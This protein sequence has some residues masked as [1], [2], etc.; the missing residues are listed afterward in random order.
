LPDGSRV[1]AVIAPLAIDGP[2]LTIRKFTQRVLTLEDLVRLGTLTG[3]VG[4]FLAACVT[5]RMNI[6]I[7]GGTGTSNAPLLNV[8]SS[9]IPSNERTVTHRDPAH[10]RVPR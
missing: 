10:L 7:S 4:D 3:T 6:L 8:L 9:M 5:G 2:Q 1:N